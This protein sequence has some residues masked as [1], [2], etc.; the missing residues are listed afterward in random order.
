MCEVLRDISAGSE[1]LSTPKVPLQLRDLLGSQDPYS[2]R[3]SG[4]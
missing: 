1:L 4:K 3:E 2:D